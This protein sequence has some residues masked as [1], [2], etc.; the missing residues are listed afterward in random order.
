M[1]RGLSHTLVLVS[2]ESHPHGRQPCQNSVTRKPRLLSFSKVVATALRIP[3]PRTT[4]L[5]RR[6]SLVHSLRHPPPL[7]RPCG[8]PHCVVKSRMRPL[9]GRSDRSVPAPLHRPLPCPS[10]LHPSHCRCPVLA[11]LLLLLPHPPLRQAVVP[12]MDRRTRTL[13]PRHQKYNMS[14]SIIKDKPRTG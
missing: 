2:K 8:P 1:S 13:H 5:P 14:M 6:R 7:T 3:L 9:P 12:P 4:A 11:W 10:L